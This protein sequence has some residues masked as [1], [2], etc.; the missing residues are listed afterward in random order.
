MRRL[1]TIA[2]AAA[3]LTLAGCGADDDGDRTRPAATTARP[4]TPPARWRTH[5]DREAGL[6]LALPPGWAAERSGGALRIRAPRRRLVAVVQADRS[7]AGRATPAGEYALSAL[8]A[9]PGYRELEGRTARPPASPYEAARVAASGT[10]SG[11]RQ[12]V[13]V[14]A[15]HVPDEVTVSAVA[16]SHPGARAERRMLDRALATLRVAQRSG[17]SG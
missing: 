15:L 1:A 6:T 8:A 16:F 9:L 7:P 12:H 11:T 17:R 10:R 13:S 5:A 14:T 3:A 4:A 2:L